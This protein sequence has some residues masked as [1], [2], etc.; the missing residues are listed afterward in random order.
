MMLK[1]DIGMPTQPLLA[2]LGDDA[3]ENRCREVLEHAASRVL[4]AGVTITLTEWLGLDADER[5]AFDHA[6]RAMIADDMVET[7]M[8]AVKQSLITE[9]E[10]RAAV[11]G[12]PYA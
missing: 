1:A 9:R 4:Q 2:D 6:A 10:I 7:A 8:E 11:N 5:I 12:G 3:R